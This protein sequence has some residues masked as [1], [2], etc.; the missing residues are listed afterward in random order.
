MN[1]H[2]LNSTKLILERVRKY[3]NELTWYNIVKYIDQKEEAEKDPPVFAVL[4]QLRED[5]FLAS[6]GSVKNI[7]KYSITK[8]G[9]ALL[10]QLSGAAITL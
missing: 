5:G 4:K 1:L 10:D 8:T 6:D 2:N 3:D 7:S 9:L